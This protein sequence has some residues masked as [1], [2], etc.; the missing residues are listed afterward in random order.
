MLNSTDFQGRSPVLRK[1]DFQRYSHRVSLQYL[2][3]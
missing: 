1:D 2:N 3:V